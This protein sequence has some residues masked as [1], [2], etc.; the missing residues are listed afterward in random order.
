LSMVLK[1]NPAIAEYRVR[2]TESGVEVDVVADRPLDLEEVRAG[3]LRSLAGAGATDA[4][5]TVTEVPDI[6]RQ[7]TGKVRRFVPLR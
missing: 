4:T 1:S 5:V 7:A 3:L 6:P 2:Q